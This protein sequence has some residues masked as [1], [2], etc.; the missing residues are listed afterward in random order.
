VFGKTL[1]LE[2]DDNEII[3][4]STKMTDEKLLTSSSG[5]I[6]SKNAF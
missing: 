6:W 3:A 4:F 2:T 1:E 5:Q